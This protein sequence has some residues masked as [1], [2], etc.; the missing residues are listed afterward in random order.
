M[1]IPCLV[2]CV[3]YFWVTIQ[4]IHYKL[5]YDL[6]IIDRYSGLARR[7]QFVENLHGWTEADILI[8][9]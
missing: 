6:E 4:E 3:G 9:S 1:D 5:K 7:D 2:R 8:F